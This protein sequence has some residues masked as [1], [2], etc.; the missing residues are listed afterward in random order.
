MVRLKVATKRAHTEEIKLNALSEAQLAA[1][2][3][4]LGR[5]DSILFAS[6]I[7]LGTQDAAAIVEHKRNQVEKILENLPRM[8]YAEGRELIEELAGRVQ[9]LSPQLYTQM[10]TQIDLLDQ[11]YRASTLYYAQRVPATLGSFRW[12]ID[13]KNASRP[14]FEET[15]RH[16]APPLLQTK[17]LREPTVFVNEFDYS[18]FDRSFGWAPG[19]MPTYLQEETGVEMKSGSNLGKILKDSRFV[20]SHDVPGVQI[21]DLLTSSIRRV[22]RNDFKDNLGM[23][24]KLGRLLVQRAKPD[25]PIH[26]ISLCEE[27]QYAQGRVVDVVRLMAKAARPMFK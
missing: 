21:A 5:L 6:C 12:R 25:P 18:H 24:Q 19:E 23:A 13:E 14:V 10:V 8:I 2:L 15:M 7:D 22:L 4:D 17:S 26:L 3:A 11:V 27:G 16:L 1:F 20:K 9:R